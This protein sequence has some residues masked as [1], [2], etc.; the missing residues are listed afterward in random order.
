MKI[1]NRVRIASR[2]TSVSVAT[3]EERYYLNVQHWKWWQYLR[4]RAYHWY[5]MRFPAKIPG[6]NRFEDFLRNHGANYCIAIGDPNP[7]IRD[8]L[9]AWTVQ[10][11]L[12]CYQFSIGCRTNSDNHNDLFMKEI[13]KEEFDELG[14][15]GMPE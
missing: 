7:R 14:K 5:D 11:D 6:W 2:S 3:G 4:Y 9:L 10:Q 12:R 8:R 15:L 13:T 1:A